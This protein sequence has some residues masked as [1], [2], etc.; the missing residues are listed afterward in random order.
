MESWCRDLHEHAR[1]QLGRIEGFTASLGRLL[2]AIASQAR[3]KTEALER[4]GRPQKITCE[5]L[6]SVVVIG[7]NSLRRLRRVGSE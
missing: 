7:P 6:D 4:Q 5:P 3:L 2:M 1:Q